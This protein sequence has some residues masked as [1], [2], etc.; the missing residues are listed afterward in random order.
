MV[1]L[2]LS[3]TW[4]LG[5][6][7]GFS[8]GCTPEWVTRLVA[9]FV[10]A[11]AGAADTATAIAISAICFNVLMAYSPWGFPPW[12]GFVLHSFRVPLA[13]L[14]QK[15]PTAPVEPALPLAPASALRHPASPG[16]SACAGTEIPRT[17]V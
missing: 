2:S 9:Y 17:S 7:V 14:L 1:P 8:A 13:Y 12:R 11:R 10:P 16:A 4:L 6:S 5:E 15:R 3:L